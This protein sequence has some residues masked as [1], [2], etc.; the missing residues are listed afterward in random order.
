MDLLFLMV[1]MMPEEYSQWLREAG[2]QENACRID[3]Q[4]MQFTKTALLLKHGFERHGFHT[5]IE[6]QKKRENLLLLN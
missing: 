1:F 2:F 4:R 3:I 5:H 6:C